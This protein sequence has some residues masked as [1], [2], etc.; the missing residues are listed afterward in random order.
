MASP[1]LNIPDQVDSPTDLAA[2]PIIT[3][4]YESNLHDVIEGWFRQHGANRDVLMFAIAWE[5]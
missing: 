2:W 3:L 4:G 1:L 5:L